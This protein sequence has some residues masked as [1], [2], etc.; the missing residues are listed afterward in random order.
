MKLFLH[1]GTPK[2]A[3]T[4]LQGTFVKNGSWLES[5]GLCYPNL[6]NGPKGNH[7]TL[8]FAAA[9]TIS[10]FAR[11]YGIHTE[12]E[13]KS[14]EKKLDAHIANLV[15]EAPDHIDSFI[16]SSENLVANMG[17][18][19][20]VELKKMLAPYFDEIKVI[21]YIRRQDDGLLSM[22]ST[23]MRR[24]FSSGGFDEYIDRMLKDP[25]PNPYIDYAK[26]I[27]IWS[28]VF[29]R[30]N[31]IVRRFDKAH[32][33]GDSGILSDFMSV[34]KGGTVDI[35]ETLE[36]A[37]DPNASLSAPLLAYLAR[38]NVDYPFTING[39]PDRKRNKIARVLN[40]LP[41]SCKPTM[42]PEMS[43]RIMQFFATSNEEIRSQWFPDDPELFGPASAVSQTPTLGKLSDREFQQFDERIQK[44]L[45]QEMPPRAGGR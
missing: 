2:T 14:F 9:R 12:A 16:F 8:L 40:D 19:G 24:G 36:K 44:V 21:C 10:A 42:S 29:G 5:L 30:D 38:L 11:E 39:V 17:Q 37:Q 13:R 23:H 7:I 26:L 20:V 35:P 15:K 28:D 6:L 34:I 3:T 27:S 1:I 43:H 18:R 4:F 41:Y 32:F 25:S 22:Y 33:V 45:A 31:I